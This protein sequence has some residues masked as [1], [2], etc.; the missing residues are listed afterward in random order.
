MTLF[1]RLF[2]ITIQGFFKKRSSLNEVSSLFFKVYYFDIDLNG[3]L[4]NSKYL[5]F[6][7]LG[8]FRLIQQYGLLKH[9]ILNKMFPV[10]Q[11]VEMSF[12]KEI[13]PGEII[14]LKTKL[15]GFDEKYIYIEQLFYVKN[16]LR[17]S[18]RIRGVFLSS[19]GIVSPNDVFL[20]LKDQIVPK[21]PES[22]NLWKIYL[23]AKK[24]ENQL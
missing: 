21:L 24:N 12:I 10:L 11:S 13:K 22:I 1:F 19:K 4:T 16:E 20:L 5:S 23:Q 8:R 3:H 2:L 14:E 6:M 15:I 18:A 9:F 17:C 7:D